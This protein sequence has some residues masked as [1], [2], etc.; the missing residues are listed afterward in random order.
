MWPRRRTM[1][2]VKVECCVP[3]KRRPI[4]QMAC[5]GSEDGVG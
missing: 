1:Y 5:G 2:A 3:T 4:A